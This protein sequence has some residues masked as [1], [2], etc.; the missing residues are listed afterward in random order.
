MAGL[1][2]NYQPNIALLQAAQAMRESSRDGRST[3][4][5]I[6]QGLLGWAG[7]KQ[8]LAAQKAAQEQAAFDRQ[9]KEDQ[10]AYVRAQTNA[11]SNPKPPNAPTAQQNYQLAQLQGYKG[12]FMEYQT[13]IKNAGRTTI[14]NNVGGNP[15]PKAQ[16]GFEWVDESNLSLG[17]RVIKGT[18][19]EKNLNNVPDA[20]AKASSFA[21]RMFEAENLI[22]GITGA[23]YDP[24]S[25]LD[26][27]AG[28][29]GVLG[30][31]VRSPEGQ[32]YSQA[33]KDWKSVV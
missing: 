30:N 29:A 27:A 16:P 4:H 17:Q 26:Q 22:A 23:G 19:Q 13:E 28:G 7:G 33:Q 8:S 31:L 3:G 24:T 32:R 6:T 10:Q 5:G 2:D 25:I 11:I 18:H 14:T 15:I 12:S 21:T 20:Q 1:L 9:Y